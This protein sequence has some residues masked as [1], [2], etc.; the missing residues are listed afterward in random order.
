MFS[1]L[2]Q[3]NNKQNI[4]PP[5]IEVQHFASGFSFGA[6]RFD[7]NGKPYS[8]YGITLQFPP[9]TVETHSCHLCTKKPSE[10]TTPSPEVPRKKAK[11]VKRDVPDNCV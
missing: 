3:A 6:I 7:E 11:N 2:L 9:M 5:Q 4:P 10:N 1:F 8:P